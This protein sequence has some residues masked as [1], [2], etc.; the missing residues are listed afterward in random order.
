MPP[1]T[2]PGSLFEVILTPVGAKLALKTDFG[3]LENQSQKNMKKRAAVNF[4]RFE[5]HP[6]GPLKGTCRMQTSRPA[7]LKDI[8]DTPLVPRGHGGGLMT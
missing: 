6:C 3:G 4:G 5:S 1:G 7:D 8:R 2:L